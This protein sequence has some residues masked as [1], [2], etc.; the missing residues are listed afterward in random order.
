MH[1]TQEADITHDDIAVQ[2]ANSGEGIFDMFWMGVFMSSS[3]YSYFWDIRMDWGLGRPKHGFL[4]PRLMFPKKNMYYLVMI[5]DLFLRFMWVTTLIPPQSGAAF[6]IPQYLSLVTMSMELFRR[7]IWGFLR[8]EHEH[9]HNTQGF[10]RVDFVP[11]HFSTETSHK[12]K[13]K[14]HAGWQVLSEVIAVTLVVLT[15]SAWSV[16]SAQKATVDVSM[17]RD[18]L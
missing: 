18:D 14:E 8:L 7:T 15:I 3:L 1:V 13:K 5:A 17:S 12:D 2:I 11:L 9:R 4:G 10:R 16:I 6:E